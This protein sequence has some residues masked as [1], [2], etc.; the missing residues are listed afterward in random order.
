MPEP[1]DSS[2]GHPCYNQKHDV[3]TIKHSGIVYRWTNCLVFLSQ[4]LTIKCTLTR[5]YGY[6][7][8]L[9]HDLPAGLRDSGSL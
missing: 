6:Q 7:R 9:A 8:Q 3:L 2:R 1:W 4:Y 5:I